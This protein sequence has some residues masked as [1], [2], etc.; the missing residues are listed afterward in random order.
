MQPG[1]QR[2]MEDINKH[3][4]S[5]FISDRVINKHLFSLFIT[6]TDIE[7]LFSSISEHY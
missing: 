7:H 3:L 6:S 2:N 4:F 1:A 5:L